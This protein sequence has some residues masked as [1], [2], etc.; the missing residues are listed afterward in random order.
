MDYDLNT[1]RLIAG[2]KN[3]PIG[4]DS[5]QINEEKALFDTIL[6][7]LAFEIPDSGDFSRAC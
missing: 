6:E 2:Q 5:A 1:T 3:S 7:S 4:T